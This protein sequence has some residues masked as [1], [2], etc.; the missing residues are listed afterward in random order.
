MYGLELS[1]YDVLDG[2]RSDV[3]DVRVRD[4]VARPVVDDVWIFHGVLS[5]VDGVRVPNNVVRSEGDGAQVTG[6]VV[7]SNIGDVR[8][9]S[10]VVRSDISGV[11]VQDDVVT[12]VAAV[13][14][15]IQ[16]HGAL[17]D[18]ERTVDE[19]VCNHEGIVAASGVDTSSCRCDHE[20]SRDLCIS[21]WGRRRPDPW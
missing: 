3:G 12:T 9:T 17:D 10:G 11:R 1:A 7:R 2:V 19:G 20:R 6:D 5:D 4:G 14:E 18:V 13:V 15:P 16:Q 8:V 21:K